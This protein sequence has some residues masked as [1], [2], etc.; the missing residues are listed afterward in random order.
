MVSTESGRL[1]RHMFEPIYTS[2]SRKIIA[3][4]TLFQEKICS[5]D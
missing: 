5:I 1:F 3:R 2:G 4:T